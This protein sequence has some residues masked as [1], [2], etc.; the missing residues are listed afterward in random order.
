M[1]YLVSSVKTQKEPLLRMSFHVV[2]Q[3]GY[4]LSLSVPYHISICL[5]L[6]IYPQRIQILEFP[7][8]IEETRA[9]SRGER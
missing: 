3:Y 4:A 2:T 7:K 8:I 1:N 9:K 6:M 5:F